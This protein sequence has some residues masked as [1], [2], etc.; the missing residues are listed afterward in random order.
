MVCEADNTKC[1]MP[2]TRIQ[3]EFMKEVRLTSSSGQSRT[4]TELINTVYFPGVG[5]YASYHGEKAERETLQLVYPDEQR[6]ITPSTHG[7][8]VACKYY[9][10]VQPLF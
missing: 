4:F 9:I 6:A 1:G 7:H 10:L 3:C 5:S 8:L 2:I